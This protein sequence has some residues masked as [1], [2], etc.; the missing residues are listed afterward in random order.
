MTKMHATERDQII[1]KIVSRKG[2]VSFRALSVRVDASPSTLRRDLARLR[3]TGKLMP[4]GPGVQWAGDVGDI[5]EHR[6]Q[7]DRSY[8]DVNANRAVEAIGKAA[9]ELCRPGEAIIIDGGGTTLAMCPHLEP[10][11]LQVLTNSL[12][13]V[14]ALLHQP[15]TRISVTAGVVLREQNI[16]HGPIEDVN[17]PRFHAS[18][19]FLGSATVTSHG[20]MQSDIVLAQAQQKLFSQA[21][22][23]IVTVESSKFSAS[24]GFLLCGLKRVHAVVTD[25]DVS[26]K[27]AKM[28]ES[29]GVR[30]I[31]AELWSSLRSV[32]GPL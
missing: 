26:D 8:Q 15:N 27:C 16:V 13:I 18:K 14:S 32:R 30:L 9:A 20:L 23:L 21:D 31:T 11:R 2:F 22:D 3:R 1:L 10:L 25:S 6:P 12:S 28:I 17:T 19:M 7:Y 29:H 4:V 5:S 24:S